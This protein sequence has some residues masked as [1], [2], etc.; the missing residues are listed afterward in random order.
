[1]SRT[2]DCPAT[3]TPKTMACRKTEPQ[4]LYGQEVIV[5]RTSSNRKKL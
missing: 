5:L 3:G 1:M 2:I 4:A